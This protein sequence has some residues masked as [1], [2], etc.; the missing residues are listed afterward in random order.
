VVDEIFL[1]GEIQ[2]TSRSVVVSRLREL[3]AEE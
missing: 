3:D 2:E 1:G